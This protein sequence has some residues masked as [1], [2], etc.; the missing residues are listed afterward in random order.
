[1]SLQNSKLFELF[2]SS[3]NESSFK[4]AIINEIR[5]S[6]ENMDFIP[7]VHSIFAN[8]KKRWQNANRT[9]EY[10]NKKNSEWLSKCTTFYN[11]EKP[12]TST[13]RQSI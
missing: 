9:N 5:V 1:M 12:H 11:I 3:E 2:R 6:A 7:K 10:F 4:L 13:D 8:I